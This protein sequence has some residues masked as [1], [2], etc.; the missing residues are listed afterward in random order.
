RRAAISQRSSRGPGARRHARP[1]RGASTGD[2]DRRGMPVDAGSRE[3]RRR[4][5]AW[6]AE[7]D[8]LYRYISGRLL[9]VTVKR[10][11]TAVDETYKL[12]S[13]LR[14]AWAQAATSGVIA[15]GAQ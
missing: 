3:W 12:M 1:R 13:T 4:G 14:E 9:D 2:C 5:G 6:G 15:A 10:D 11:A 8:G 7:L